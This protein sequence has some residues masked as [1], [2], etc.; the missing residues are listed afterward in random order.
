MRGKAKQACVYCAKDGDFIQEGMDE[1]LD[2]Y[3]KKEYEIV[4]ELKNRNIKSRKKCY[5]EIYK[6]MFI[7]KIIK[8][9]KAPAKQKEFCDAMYELIVPST[10]FSWVEKSPREIVSTLKVL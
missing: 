9:I 6:M 10:T 4:E 2:G 1:Y 7:E 3:L 8:V 5:K